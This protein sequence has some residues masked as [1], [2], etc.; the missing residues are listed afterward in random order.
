VNELNN[1]EPFS[2]DS[3]PYYV[4]YPEIYDSYQSPENFT[5]NNIHGVYMHQSSISKQGT[6]PLMGNIQLNY[7]FKRCNNV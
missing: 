4:N 1:N 5:Q 7:E 2:Y 3:E 6:I